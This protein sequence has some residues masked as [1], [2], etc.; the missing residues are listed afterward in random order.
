MKNG[1]I[2]A[3]NVSTAL[4]SQQPVV[5]LES[6]LITHGLP[7]PLNIN[8]AMEMEEAVRFENVVPATIGLLSGEV[9]IGLNSIQLRELG[10][11][12][13]AHKISPRDL[14]AAAV[15][16][17][18]GGT[19][20]AG[21]IFLAEKAG[22]KVFATGGI[23]G[24]HRGDAFDVSADLAQ[25]A[26]TPIIVVCAGAKVILDLPATLEVLESY[27]VPV[28]GYKT[29]QFPAFICRN[30]GLKLEIVAHSPNEVS[31]IASSHW[32]FGNR[33]ALLV[34][35][36]VPGEFALE[37]QLV[38]SYVASALEEANAKRIQGKDVTPFLLEKLKMRSGEKSLKANI[39]LLKN[40]AVVAAM[41]ANSLSN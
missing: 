35:V 3:D 15:K 29:N 23:G 19:T 38:D 17:W 12:K 25:L 31:E 18:N 37:F 30:S 8:T 28:I 24:V 27:G 40:N 7:V 5:A 9:L 32:Q 39:A 36:P 34:V 14:A 16:G 41:I 6:A 2:I 4:A 20:V 13:G 11:L 33:S 21:T 26:N 1:F 22:I 10:N